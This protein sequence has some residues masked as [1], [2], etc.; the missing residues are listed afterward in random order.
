MEIRIKIT[1]HEFDDLEMRRKAAGLP[2]VTAYAR[3]L[4]F[5]Q[6]KYQDLWKDFCEHVKNLKKGEVFY[7]RDILATPPALL[8]R[9]VF[10]A[11]EQLGIE[12]DGKDRTGTNRWRKL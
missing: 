8:G 11:Q 4:L 3:S 1:K 12:L 9:W 10:E 2:S 5:P 7:V 6:Q